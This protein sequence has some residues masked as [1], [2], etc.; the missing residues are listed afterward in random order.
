MLNIHKVIIGVRNII[1]FIKENSFQN[2]QGIPTVGLNIKKN[3]SIRV[4]FEYIIKFKRL[5]INIICKY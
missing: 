2:L 5:K 3:D 1:N 4:H